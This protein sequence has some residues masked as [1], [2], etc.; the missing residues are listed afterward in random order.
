MEELCKYKWNFN[1]DISQWNVGNVTDMYGMFQ[2][3]RAFNQPLEQW[4]VGNVTTME[5]MFDC[6]V[7]SSGNKP[8][9][10]R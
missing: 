1:D 4:N 2:G 7:I 10:L 5:R 3:A 8:Q 6:A 9:W